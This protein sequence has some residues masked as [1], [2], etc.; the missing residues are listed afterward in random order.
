M[1]KALLIM[2][3][4]VTALMIMS[5]M[6]INNITPT[7]NN[8]T[9]TGITSTLTTVNTIQL[10]GSNSYIPANSTL[11]SQ[12]NPLSSTTIYIGLN[13]VNNTEL[14]QSIK[15]ASTPGSPMYGHYLSK[16]QFESA[17]E[18]SANTYNNIAGYYQSQGFKIVNTGSRLNIGING[19]F[20][21]IE[22]TFNTNIS[23]YNTSLG[24]YYFNTGNI[25]IPQEFS[26]IINSAIGFN[27]YPYFTPQ[28]LVNPASGDNLS[29]ALNA[30]NNG[31]GGQVPQPPYTPY[32][33]YKAY[34]ELPLLNSGYQGQYETIA[35]TDA[36]GDPTASADLA[37]YDALYNVS[38]PPSFNV[39]Y[40][41]GQ[42]ALGT[43]TNDIGSV[44]TLWEV[45]SS[46]D[47]EMS[48]GFAPQANVVDVVSPDAD[49]TLTQSLVNIIE[50]HLANVISN[51]WGA[52]EPEVGSC[53]DY[54]HPFFKMAAATGITVLAAS[55]DNGSAGYDP[56]VPRSIIWPSNDPYV[57]AVGGTTIFMNGTISTVQNP[58][59]GP[60]SVTEVY[61]PIAMVNETAWDG[62]S[63]GGYSVV[64]TRPYWQH[65]YGLPTTG[66]HAYRRGVPD[67]AA[68]AMFG[69][70]D[71]VFNGLTAG[72]FLFGGTSFASPTWAGIVATMDSY[73][74]SIQG[75][76]LGYLNPALYSILNSP[77]Y[78]ESFYNVKYGYNGPDGLFN[79]H[80]GWNPVTGLGS[81]ETAF[82][83]KELAEYSFKAG[84][85]SDYN[86]TNNTGLSA[87]IQTVLPDRAVGT[88]SNY[89]YISEKLSTGTKLMLGYAVNNK[90]PDG[91]IF[92]A[93]IPSASLYETESINYLG[94][95]TAGN[96]GTFNNYTIVETSPNACSMEM[97]FH[98]L[99]PGNLHAVH[100]N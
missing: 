12:A 14:N 88:S 33:L 70:N 57:T 84:A 46:L 76:Q 6:P 65:G 93:I 77:V 59:N 94:S 87:N 19:T 7:S 86:T 11:I 45:E 27:N 49:Y 61:N 91:T 80:A 13:T 36:Y 95:S 50:N 28:L 55:G 75:V 56:N 4:C 92:Y 40:P 82:L 90:Y 51:S 74:A 10:N 2:V 9:N 29:Q 96:N 30:T 98:H 71:F 99:L 60:P 67:V 8:N 32:A 44:E 31:A 38:T 21:Q 25:S 17:F 97:L 16:S 62:Y 85:Y 69:G 20:T 47:I 73:I 66:K 58:L 83:A 43:V 42:S 68:N 35:V 39:I 22:N 15:L 34:N 5:V 53:I 23:L 3:F 64:F 72:S 81:P 24:I 100:I 37:E 89:F 1:K 52:P 54:T 26:G 78:N 41:Y 18:P 79:A 48:H 63:G